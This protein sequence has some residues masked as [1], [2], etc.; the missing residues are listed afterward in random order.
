MPSAIDFISRIIRII[1]SIAYER[2]SPARRPE[3]LKCFVNTKHTEKKVKIE[4]IE[5]GK[6][7]ASEEKC[8]SWPSSELL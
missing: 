6:S 5:P 3:E 7:E 4:S 2:K 8:S 1:K